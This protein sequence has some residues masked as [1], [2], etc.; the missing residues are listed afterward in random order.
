MWKVTETFKKNAPPLRPGGGGG[1][2]GPLA[3]TSRRGCD[4]LAYADCREESGWIDC[5]ERESLPRCGFIKEVVNLSD[6]PIEI[7]AFFQEAGATWHTVIP[8]VKAQEVYTVPQ[9]ALWLPKHTLLR[10]VH[11]GTQDEIVAFGALGD[12][13]RL[14][15]K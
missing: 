10:S 12:G 9:G 15:Q 6:N 14:V 3:T 4:R 7:Q 13:L 11:Q 8:A 2:L 5:S 1:V